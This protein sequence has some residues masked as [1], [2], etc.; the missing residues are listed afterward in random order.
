VRL[1][2]LLAVL[3]LVLLLL[4]LLLLLLK[5]KVMVSTMRTGKAIVSSPASHPRGRHQRAAARRAETQGRRL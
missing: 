5:Q 2:M 1:L 4:L 3:L